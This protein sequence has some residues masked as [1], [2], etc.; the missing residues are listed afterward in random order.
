[1]PLRSVVDIPLHARAAA[2]VGVSDNGVKASGRTLRHLRRYGF[3]GVICPVN[4]HAEHGPEAARLRPARRRARGCGPGGDRPAAGGCGG[5]GTRP[6]RAGIVFASGYSQ[7]GPEG[8]LRQESL[9][10]V[11]AEA[12][13]RILGPN[14]VGAVSAGNALTA[15]F[16]TGL[17]QDRFALQDGGIAFVSES[18]AMG[19]FILNLAQSEGIGVGRFL[20]TGNEAN[21][22]LPALV[23]LL[24][25]EGSTRVVLT[26]VEGI[27]DGDAF[28][29]ALTRA[30][31]RD[32]PVCALKVGRKARGAAAAPSQTGVLAGSQE[33]TRGGVSHERQQEV[34]RGDQRSPGHRRGH[35]R[36]TDS[37]RYGRRRRRP[38]RGRARRVPAT[39]PACTRK[40]HACRTDV[41]IEA[42]WQRLLDTVRSAYGLFTALANAAVSPK[43]DGQRFPTSEMP[44]EEWQDGLAVNL[45][46]AYLGCKLVYPDM[47][48]AG[49]GLIVNISS[50]AAR[51][52]A[53]VAGVHYGSTKAGP[54]GLTRT[55]S[56]E[57]GPAGITINAVTPGRITTPN[58]GG[59]CRRRQ[60]GDT[61]RH[62]RRPARQ[63]QGHGLGRE[64]PGLG[65]GR[66][67]NRRDHRC[68]RRQFYG[69]IRAPGA[70][71]REGTG[72][73]L[74]SV[75]P[76]AVP[77]WRSRLRP[78]GR[79]RSVPLKIGRHQ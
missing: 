21:L 2:I 41:S 78:T 74:P 39:R 15:T 29:R 14:S 6:W 32:I 59:S 72:S 43:Q 40:R 18:G 11:A 10:A 36:R 55:L 33:T 42:G 8:Q 46:G 44:M 45:T 49:W 52:S 1:M 12:E 65:R 68:Q 61:A 3:D 70:S 7:T 79:S 47:L 54:L 62:T 25:D 73:H 51:T 13:V 69:L 56:V 4:P 66:V 34:L 37:T 63:S 22:T 77:G 53:R 28:E 26:Y 75:A 19:G 31:E 24:V 67:R 38:G 9:R 76:M 30:R 27:G 20:S 48:R 71:P 16:M 17:D 64:L 23:H 50:Q 57:Y 60:P 35:H 5:C 58:V